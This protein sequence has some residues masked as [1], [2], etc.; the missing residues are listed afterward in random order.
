M[1]SYYKRIKAVIQTWRGKL[2]SFTYFPWVSEA[3]SATTAVSHGWCTRVRVCVR[4]SRKACGFH[5]NELP[6]FYIKYHACCEVLVRCPYFKDIWF[7]GCREFLSGIH[8]ECHAAWGTSSIRITF[9]PLDLLI[10]LL[11][12]II[13]SHSCPS[14]IDPTW[15]WCSFN[16][17]LD[18]MDEYFT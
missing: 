6:A 1:H 18:L 14:G 16:T 2:E 13:P 10:M 12:C 7:L 15:L 3:L 17:P 11:H 9:S 5:E 8:F 4:V